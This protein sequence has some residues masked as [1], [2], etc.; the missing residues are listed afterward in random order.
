MFYTKWMAKLEQVEKSIY[1][2]PCTLTSISLRS[3]YLRIRNGVY[4]FLLGPYRQLWWKGTSVDSLWPW[5]Y[6][7][8]TSDV[9][10]YERDI[11]VTP[12]LLMPANYQPPPP[13]PLRFLIF[14]IYYTFMLG[15]Y[16]QLWWKG[17]FRLRFVLR[18][19]YYNR[20]TAI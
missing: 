17:T 13:L 8:S 11:G 2:T 9:S 19:R 6:A 4:T 20:V 3:A 5:Q 18:K 1:P 12:I 16:R 14:S 7:C 10:C 15:P